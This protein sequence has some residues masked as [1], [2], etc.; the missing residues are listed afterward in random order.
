MKIQYISKEREREPGA[1]PLN[2]SILVA[3]T[4]FAA[5]ITPRKTLIIFPHFTQA[6]IS[7]NDS[8]KL[9][10]SPHRKNPVHI[11]IPHTVDLFKIPDVDQR[12]EKDSF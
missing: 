9:A 11:K 5:M 4:H 7:S 12:F 8:E 10:R 3:Q 6:K 1:P 2:H